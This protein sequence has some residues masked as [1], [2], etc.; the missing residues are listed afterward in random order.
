[1]PWPT[2][3]RRQAKTRGKEGGEELSGEGHSPA[4]TLSG[5]TPSP[6]HPHPHTNASQGALPAAPGPPVCPPGLAPG[7]PW[8]PW[9]WQAGSWQPPRLGWSLASAPP[10]P[11]GA[12]PA[13]GHGALLSPL[14]PQ[15]PVVLHESPH[16]VI[17]FIIIQPLLPTPK[18]ITQSKLAEIH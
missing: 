15:T 18:F 12:G 3:H 13:H 8:P 14:P 7:A 11:A 10:A 6:P 9:G 2:P 1:M 16:L 5:G 17:N 4:P